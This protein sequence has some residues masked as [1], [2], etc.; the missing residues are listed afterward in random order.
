MGEVGEI[1]LLLKD[2]H[3]VGIDEPFC[4]L[5]LRLRHVND[6]KALGR[7]VQL[8]KEVLG[9]GLALAV[10]VEDDPHGRADVV[11]FLDRRYEFPRVGVLH[12][13]AYTAARAQEVDPA[14]G[15]RGG[16]RF[17]GIRF[18]GVSHRCRI[19]RHLKQFVVQRVLRQQAVKFLTGQ[20][21]IEN[22][23]GRVI[24]PDGMLVIGQ[25]LILLRPQ[26]HRVA[27]S[28]AVFLF[29]RV[30]LVIG[31]FQRR[32]KGAVQ[33][34]QHSL[35]PIRQLWSLLYDGPQGVPHHGEDEVALSGAGIHFLV[36]IQKCGGAGHQIPAVWGFVRNFAIRHKRLIVTD[37]FVKIIVDLTTGLSNCR[38]LPVSGVLLLFRLVQ[39]ASSGDQFPNTLL[40]LGPGQQEFP[41]RV[42]V[43]AGDGDALA[44][45]VCPKAAAG[46]SVGIGAYAV[47]RF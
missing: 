45:V 21:L 41:V 42:A 16:Q 26:V 43:V 19:L 31:R 34:G 39:V 15:Q 4:P 9:D 33:C 38:L 47:F 40:H 46:D 1:G 23:K 37:N 18:F 27:Q 11:F 7:R 14:H 5:Q 13:V 29:R 24:E 10:P 25:Q 17:P 28:K 8:G 44:V 2:F 20:F 30:Q 22:R 36:T 12:A 32:D 35:A 3:A 6:L